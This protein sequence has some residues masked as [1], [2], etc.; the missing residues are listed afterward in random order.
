MVDVPSIANVIPQVRAPESR[1]SPG[2]IAAPYQE[3][4]NNLNKIGE[5]VD[6]DIAQ[7]A[8]ARAG[9]EAVSADGKT[10][11]QPSIPIIGAA[12]AEFARAARFTA[13]SRMTPEIENRLAEIR[14]EHQNDPQGYQNAVKGFKDRYMNGDP[15]NG[16]AGITDPALKGPVERTILQHAGAGYRSVLEQTNQTNASNAKTAITSQITDLG[17]KMSQSAFAGGVDTPEYQRMQADMGALYRELGSDPRMGYPKERIESELSQMISQQRTM[18]L[19]GQAI[20]MMDADSPTARA[21]AKKWLVDRV[22]NDPTLNLSLSQRHQAVTTAMGLMEAR[23]AEGKAL[24]DANK[25]T[26]N[27]LLTNL[28]ST[29]PYNPIT[30]NDAITNSA[31]VG[32]A[33][34][35]YKLTFARTMH[36]WSESMRSLPMPQQVAALRALD[37]LTPFEGRLVGSESSG[38]PRLINQ[39]GYAGLYQFGA[40]RL[41]D[42]GVYTP[43][44]NENMKDWSKTS[45]GAAG[46]WSGTFHVPGFP[47]VKTIEDFR[48]NPAAQQAA[49][50]VHT[51]RMDRE[52]S[53]LGLDKY[54]GKTVGGAMINR[55]A[56]YG[57]IHLGGAQGAADALASGG[58]RAARDANG[59]SVMDYAKKFGGSGGAGAA[60]F[61]EARIEQV[62]RTRDYL[63]GQAG[64]YVD[65]VVKMLNQ[66]GDVPD[67]VLKNTADV[68]RETGQDDQRAKIDKAL[69]SHYGVQALD[70]LPQATRL[71]WA[72]QA[73]IAG[74]GGNLEAADAAMK[75]TPQ[76][77]ALYQRHLTNLNGPGGV[78]NP[79]GSR[80]TLYQATVD[81]GGKTYSIPT[82]WDGKILSVE[83]AVKRVQAEGWDKFPAY[84]SPEEAETRYQKMH[85]FME[86]DT[87]A[88]KQ[89]KSQD[90][91][92]A[93]Q[94]HEQMAETLKANAQAMEKSPYSTWAVRSQGK[95]P[96]VYDFNDPGNIGAVA[97]LRASTQKTIRANDRTGPISV[98]EGEEAKAFANTLTNGDANV[99]AGALNSL[100]SLPPDI[101]E[102]TLAQKPIADA[103]AG[104]MGS[105]E[106]AR[107]SAAMQ[108]ADK[109]WRAEPMAAEAALGKDGVTRMQAWQGLQGSF[110]AA[111][112]AER[113]NAS[114][115]PSTRKAR[116]EAREAAETET[117]AMTPADMA[118]KLGTGLPLIGRLTGSTPAAPFDGIK[119]GEL[120]ADYRTT[121]TALRAYGVP[122]DQA[123]DLAV[124]RLQSTWGVSAAAGNQVMKNP[125]ERVYPA[126]AGSHDWLAQD[127]NE[128]IGKRAGPEFAA[129]NRSIEAGIGLAGSERRWSVEGLI[130]DG[131]TTAEIAAGRPASY[132]V[133]IKKADGM[134]QILDSRVAFD[135]TS[136]VAEHEARLEQRRQ[137]VD[138][139]RAGQF[140]NAMPLP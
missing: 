89:G 109:L 67:D 38:N 122:S 118:Y 92:I 46:K 1:V 126:I 25:G 29:Q 59:T 75:L 140:S 52:I 107:M 26:V 117:K 45:S 21:D 2:Q 6:K 78:D 77:R 76:E 135:P 116:Q 74:R 120:V 115:D 22:Y 20:R 64:T 124:Q 49:F 56:L 108:A 51:E 50:G 82:V 125:P 24:I 57:M 4:A 17:N 53:Q 62:N 5:V 80:S 104:M 93:F 11:T 81:H 79:D 16:V 90:S 39:L 68:L 84:G 129:G 114:D 3:L 133:S 33:E 43:G 128:W 91:V 19:S 65:T 31:K 119:G 112:I 8:A 54:E 134:S 113:L 61:E 71:A 69:M 127:L 99:A 28:H 97:A 27:T 37:K 98:F 66:S 101:Y 103:I 12:S 42:L 15:D 138:F 136:H 131:Q 88:Y 44:A 139:L 18:A 47:D 102:A 14:I 95:P 58:A 106:P 70:Q 86:E 30:V 111:E 105:K 96:A 41:A 32:D 87:A 83:E 13:L 130:A 9:E 123:S 85:G 137:A 7:P 60:W 110:N 35:F 40:P 34:S 121:Y 10:V 94:V 36:D 132:R 100:S 23:S 48:N 55:S 73:H 63:K 72:A